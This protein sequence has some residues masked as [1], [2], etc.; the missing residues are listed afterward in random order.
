LRIP[1]NIARAIGILTL[2]AAAIGSFY[3]LVAVGISNLHGAD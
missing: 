1:G 3:F 2:I